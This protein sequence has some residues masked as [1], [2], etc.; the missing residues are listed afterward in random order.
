MF[1]RI[2]LIILF[3]SYTGLAHAGELITAEAA[4]YY[5][6]AVKAQ[7]GGEFETARVNYNKALLLDPHN[8][9]I[10]KYVLNNMGVMFMKVGNLDKAEDYFNKALT[11]DPHYTAA[12]LNI[13]FIYEKERT[14]LESIKYW[15]KVLNIDLDSVKP[16]G[17]VVQDLVEPKK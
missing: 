11:I 14:E 17:F 12:R 4:N 7:R 2:A 9:N 16:K 5:E 1:L 15:L 6:T 8:T 13:G 10:Q 3:L